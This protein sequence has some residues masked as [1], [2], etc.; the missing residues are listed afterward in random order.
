MINITI[1]TRN[2]HRRNKFTNNYYEKV[3]FDTFLRV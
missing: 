3:D 2:K 1:K